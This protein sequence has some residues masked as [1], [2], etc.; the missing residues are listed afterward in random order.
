MGQQFFFAPPRL[1]IDPRQWNIPIDT[2]IGHFIAK[3]KVRHEDGSDETTTLRIEKSR[4][5]LQFHDGSQYFVI[6]RTPKENEGNITLHKQLSQTFKVGD[7][8]SLSITGMN[9]G[10]SVTARKEI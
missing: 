2:P 3:V 8:L 1:I 9:N 4:S 7:K 6:Q 5:Q 10:S